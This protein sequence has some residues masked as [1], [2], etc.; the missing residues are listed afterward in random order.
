MEALFELLFKYRPTLFERGEL[1][2]GVPG[3]VLLGLVALVAVATPTLLRYARARGKTD[4]RDRVLLT[5]LRVG[6]LGILV[7]SLCR[8]ALVLSTVVPQQSF[9][10]V[11]VDDSLSMRIGDGGGE[12]RSDFVRAHFGSPDSPLL[13]A[14]E[15][16]FKLR[17]L[18]FAERCAGDDLDYVIHN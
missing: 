18:R 15:A 9:V 11:L 4:R 13:Q 6:L 8:P 3:L 14:L 2:L 17:Y 16:R 12:A 1:A 5:G 10:G 7:F